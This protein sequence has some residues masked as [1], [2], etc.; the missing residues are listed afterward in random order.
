VLSARSATCGAAPRLVLSAR[1]FESSSALAF[2]RQEFSV[3]L[4][5]GGPP[6]RSSA[7]AAP[8]PPREGQHPAAGGE[9]HFEQGPAE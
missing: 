6:R 2:S 3:T 4:D 5:V 7:V 8:T 9:Q 1:I